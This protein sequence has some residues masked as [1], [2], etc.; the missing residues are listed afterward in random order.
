MLDFSRDDGMDRGTDEIHMNLMDPNG[1]EIR[2]SV[3]GDG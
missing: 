2:S 3:D 1:R